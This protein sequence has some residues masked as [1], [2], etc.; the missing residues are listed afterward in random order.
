MEDNTHIIDLTLQIAYNISNRDFSFDIYK[1][2]CNTTITNNVL[3][4]EATTVTGLGDG[5][6]V[7]DNRLTINIDNLKD[8]DI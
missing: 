5:F 8:S 6:K 1:K 7:A 3:P 2:Y 4:I